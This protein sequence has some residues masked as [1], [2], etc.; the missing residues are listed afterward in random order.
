MRITILITSLMIFLIS[1]KV[2]FAEDYYFLFSPN[3]DD[4]TI[5]E[6]NITDYTSPKEV[7]K[8]QT[9]PYWW[10]SPSR[11]AIDSE[12]NVWITNRNLNTVVKIGN[13]GA[14]N[15][16]DKN[17]NG[18]IETNIDEN[19]NGII[20]GNEMRY[21]FG[22][23]ECILKEVF[24]E[25]N[26]YIAYND[27][28]GIRAVCVDMNDNVYVGYFEI[29]KMYYVSK[30]GEIL[31]TIYLGCR[32]YGCIIDK[33]RFV[34]VSCIADNTVVK[35]DPT[36]DQ[37]YFYTIN[38]PYGISPTYA[39]DG[40]VINR[41]TDNYVT[42]INLNGNVVWSTMVPCDHGRGITVDKNDYIYGA[43][44]GYIFGPCVLKL[45]KNG[46]VIKMFRSSEYGSFFG[47][48]IDIRDNIVWVATSSCIIGLD[49]DLN[50]VVSSIC[51]GRLHYVYSDWT[52]YL[53]RMI[54]SCTSWTPSLCYNTTHRVHTRTCEPRGCSDEMKLVEDPSCS[55]QFIPF[56]IPTD[57]GNLIYAGAI[58]VLVGTI[59]SLGVGIWRK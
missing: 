12:G 29:S 34:W 46:N 47:I 4:G 35:Y 53:Y 11:T 31:K 55:Q 21:G 48:G 14:G 50:S 58:L 3:S 37:K 10:S 56:A 26:D 1:F 27:N 43:F 20:D 24:F 15:C 40:L 45:D 17:R 13:Y 57:I 22:E 25:S 8:H 23:D 52:G 7:T 18:V 54:C 42:K 33:N 51:N 28:R 32:P 6:V 44:S 2:G 9:S 16:I 39:G 49:K 30:N 5:S 41:W 38:I 59:L 19:K 36:T